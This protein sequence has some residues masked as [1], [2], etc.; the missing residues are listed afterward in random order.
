[1][2]PPLCVG[3]A[4]FGGYGNTDPETIGSVVH[5]MYT[6]LDGFDVLGACFE[7]LCD[8]FDNSCGYSNMINPTVVV[9]S[10]KACW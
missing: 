10:N 5:Y 3:G 1:M 6:C 9:V 2:V 7:C 8:R 4:R